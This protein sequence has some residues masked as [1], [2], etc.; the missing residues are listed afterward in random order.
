MYNSSF[1]EENLFS[2]S[3]VHSLVNMFAKC[4]RS[5]S[6]V[7]KKG[8][9]KSNFVFVNKV[10]S[11]K[12][13]YWGC[14]KLK[15]VKNKSENKYDM[16]QSHFTPKRCSS[17][18]TNRSSSHG[19]LKS[20]QTRSVATANS[21]EVLKDLSEDKEYYGFDTCAS[22]ERVFIAKRRIRHRVS[23]TLGISDN[24]LLNSE[25]VFKQKSDKKNKD[26]TSQES[27]KY[28]LGLCLIVFE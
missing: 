14:K 16:L 17:G 10:D 15:I 28:D 25:A 1:R 13:I 2:P 26:Q 24:T 8:T 18:C 7:A 19:R 9:Q 12:S 4:S 27:S 6:D 21:F 3:V 22:N 23:P 5:Y 20:L 11:V